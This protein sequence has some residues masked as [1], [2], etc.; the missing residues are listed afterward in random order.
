MLSRAHD[1]VGNL[2]G[3]PYLG[4]FT[5]PS[6]PSE[7]PA[8]RPSCVLVSF[9]SRRSQRTL[10]PWKNVGTN[11]PPSPTDALPDFTY[12]MPVQVVILSMTL[13]LLSIL[14]IHLLFT[15]RYHLPLSK[16]NYALQARWTAA[17]KG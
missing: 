15:I 4:Q 6:L 10:D 8:S 1:P 14:L 2:S 13:T 17:A 3:N 7:S 11:F 5:S 12:A 9:A 16:L